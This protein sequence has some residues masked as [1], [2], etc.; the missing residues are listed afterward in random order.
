MGLVGGIDEGEGSGD[1]VGD[2]EED[3]VGED[4]I[5]RDEWDVLVLTKVVGTV[6][7]SQGDVLITGIEV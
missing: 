1:K 4:R 3:E 6:H 2:L 5:V 7:V